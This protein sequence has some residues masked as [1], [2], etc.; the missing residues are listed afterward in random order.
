[1][2]VEE[3]DTSYFTRS[4]IVY[5]AALLIAAIVLWAM[6]VSWYPNLDGVSV[7]E[8]TPAPPDKGLFMSIVGKTNADDAFSAEA[9][10]LNYCVFPSVYNALITKTES[11]ILP[12]LN[13]HGLIGG[14]ASDA[15]KFWGKLDL[16]AMK[17]SY[18]EYNLPYDGL[19]AP[20]GKIEPSS[21]YYPPVCR[22]MN[23]VFTTYAAKTGDNDFPGAQ[24]ALDNCLATR[25][26]IKWQTL[27]GDTVSYEIKT[28]KYV[29][30]YALLFQLCFAFVI[31]AMYN[32]I[33]FLTDYTGKGIWDGN[34]KYFAG[35]LVSFVFLW[36]SPLCSAG[37]VDPSSSI[38]FSTITFL[39]ALVLGI[40]V[41][42]MWSF[43]AHHVDI[44]RQ[45]YMHPLS[46][47]IILSSLYTIS[48]IENGVFTLSVIVSH[49]FQSNAMSIAYA[50]MLFASH[51]K[52][53]KG[54]SSS[55]TG[56]ILLLFLPATMHVFSMI[57][58]FP[59]NCELSLLWGLPTIFATICYAKVLFI[60]HF[61]DDEPNMLGNKYKVTHSDHLLNIGHLIIVAC[62]VMY[63]VI[64]LAE[65]Q[66]GRNDSFNM[67]ATGGRLTKR[68]N[69]EFAEAGIT[70]IGK[71]LYNTLTL[72]FSDR[73]FINP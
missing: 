45:T 9:T 20:S 41:E 66:Y 17:R 38:K 34:F 55:R 58:M 10:L 18:T 4:S 54:S 68:L 14:P 43:V 22:C 11:E 35:L 44:G 48:L 16:S 71:P 26:L 40:P 49:I 33:D 37:S 64:Q 32:R 72:P 52:I 73:F 7:Y 50:G 60:D 65:L 70:G 3:R 61:M 12:V 19:V 27:I 47:Y 23:S 5:N 2:K 69:F 39:P 28:R 51:G 36:L 15:Q 30:R 13:S 24:E 56:F 42:I 57:P 1:M 8:L 25:H 67:A 46:F 62:V 53:W 31:G 59:V 21:Q 29:S 63:Y 6:N